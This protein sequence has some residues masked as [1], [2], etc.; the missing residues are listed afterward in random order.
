MTH[1]V[2]AN[3]TKRSKKLSTSEKNQSS[4]FY[5]LKVGYLKIFHAAPGGNTT[6][7]YYKITVLKPVRL[8]VSSVSRT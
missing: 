4:S 6:Q 3:D 2:R 1:W 8:S 5:A 7:E